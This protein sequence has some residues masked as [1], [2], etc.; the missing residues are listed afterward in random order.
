[1]IVYWFDLHHKIYTLPILKVFLEGI[2]QWISHISE[3]C[4]HLKPALVML[5]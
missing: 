5:V 4:A 1:M 2:I 3:V